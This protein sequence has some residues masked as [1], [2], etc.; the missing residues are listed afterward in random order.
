MSYHKVTQKSAEL[1]ED[2]TRTMA[3]N[4]GAANPSPFLGFLEYLAEGVLVVDRHRVI[5]AANQALERMSGWRVEELLGKSCQDLESPTPM[6][7]SLCPLLNLSRRSGENRGLFHELTLLTKSGS[8]LEVSASFAS[9]ELP[10]FLVPI[11]PMLE[12]EVEG[13]EPTPLPDFSIIL[14]RDITEQKRQEHIKTQFIATAS[15]QLRTPL[16]SI[17]TAI[18]LLLDSVE[19]DFSPP[20]LRL[21]QNIQESSLRIERLV[22][23]MIELTNLQNG[24]IQLQH[25][26]VEI[27]ELVQ[28]AVAFNQHRLSAKEQQLDLKLPPH[29]LYLETD[30]ERIV[31]VLGHLLSNASKFSGNGKKIG[32]EVGPS[33]EIERRPEVIF[34]VQDEGIGISPDEN[35]LIFEKFYQSQ[36]EENSSQVG[37]G[38][39]LPLAKALIELNGGRL[40]FESQPGK[41]STFYFSLPAL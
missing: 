4:D 38:L 22:K 30:V 6:C 9:L 25:C 13:G 7:L 40:W 26:R 16:A 33:A 17:K 24:R 32:L 36:I 18:G 3:Q 34:S 14:L 10:A 11:T 19:A 20:L 21:L 29:E 5:R 12:A 27:R 8:R 15:H 2:S 1:H 37:N 28:Q 23:D 31:Q 39:G 35:S 41:G